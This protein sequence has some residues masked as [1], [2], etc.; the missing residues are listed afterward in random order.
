MMAPG[1]SPEPVICIGVRPTGSVT[2]SPA[3][4]EGELLDRFR[5]DAD[6][7]APA[8][9]C[10]LDTELPGSMR[11]VPTG[12][13]AVLYVVGTPTWHGASRV[14][15]RGA[16]H[17]AGLDGASCTYDLVRRRGRW[18]VEDCRDEILH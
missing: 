5:G 3:D 1:S 12:R 9:E 7:V 14:E 2:P 8:S 10:R 6:L 17:R 4:P 18:A 16:Y 15:V 13:P 11:H